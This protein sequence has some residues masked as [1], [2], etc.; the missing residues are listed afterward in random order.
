MTDRYL[1]VAL[2]AFCATAARAQGSPG[3]ARSSLLRGIHS[4]NPLERMSA[5]EDLRSQPGGVRDPSLVM[6]LLE[7]ENQL[8]ESTWVESNGTT[9]IVDLYGEGYTEYVNDLVEECIHHCDQR[10]PRAVRALGKA[11]VGDS[12]YLVDLAVGHGSE[13]LPIA[14]ET[15]ASHWP[16]FQQKGLLML[17]SIA[18]GSRSLSERE[19]ASIDS[20]LTTCL[21][22]SCDPITGSAAADAVAHI[23]ELNPGISSVRRLK[24]HDAIV[25]ATGNSERILRRSAVLALRDLREPSDA[26]LLEK[27]SQDDP[28]PIVRQQARIVRLKLRAP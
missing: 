24:M 3:E 28:D 5:F 27:L 14:L 23:I 13:L 9:G 26:K 16:D 1:F 18:G 17:G 10:D 22:R 8:E 25:V 4:S 15:A 12:P 7:R 21:L 2:L 19:T 6:E 20:A 11:L